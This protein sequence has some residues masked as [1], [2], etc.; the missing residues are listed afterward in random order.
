MLGDFNDAS[1]DYFG[2]RSRAPY[3]TPDIR[4][5]TRMRNVFPT[6]VRTYRAPAVRAAGVRGFSDQP[7]E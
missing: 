5:S 2:G 3:A 4:A 7:S 6:C 1:F